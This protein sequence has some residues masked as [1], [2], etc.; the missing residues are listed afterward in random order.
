M[1]TFASDG[2]EK[3]SGLPVARFDA[4][5]LHAQ[6]GGQFELLDSRREMHLTPTGKEQHFIY[7]FC[8]LR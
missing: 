7:C 5:S 4:G 6:F 3:C 2:P 1:A 8:R